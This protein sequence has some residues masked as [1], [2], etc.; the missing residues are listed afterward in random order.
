MI[1]DINQT[2]VGLQ[3]MDL[4]DGVN[5]FIILH[6]AAVRVVCLS[7]YCTSCLLFFFQVSAFLLEFMF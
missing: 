6:I 1:T 4:I 3:L 2:R 7:L 5:V